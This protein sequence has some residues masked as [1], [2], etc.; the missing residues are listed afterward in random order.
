VIDG[1][2]QGNTD[3]ADLGRWVDCVEIDNVR[4][5]GGL[6]VQGG[7]VTR[8]GALY[9]SSTPEEASTADTD[10]II[11]RLGVQT[12]VDL[13]RPD[14]S[15]RDIAGP[16]QTSSAVRR[17]SLPVAGSERSVLTGS[18]GLG[19]DMVAVY[20][21]FLATGH[22]WLLAAARI[23]AE[24]A[25]RPMLVHCAAGKDR[26][27]VLVAVLLDAV[28]V[29]ISSI[30]RDYALTAQRM[31]RVRARLTRLG[32]YRHMR[33]LDDRWF[34][35]DPKTMEAFL[36]ILHD[37]HGGGTSWLRA[38]GLSRRELVELRAGL[39]DASHH[40]STE[41]DSSVPQ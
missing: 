16:W 22:G 9:R 26:T 28:G 35:A 3:A 4:D 36:G 34:R 32:Y 2:D 24:A 7:G 18:D 19:F 27:G 33:A 25:H 40:A 1:H 14:E 30:A 39:V 23:A 38:H 12:V 13:R 21:Q 17:I 20:E 10:L 5:L 31:D 37:E 8:F 15:D 11:R 29:P 41:A 6:P